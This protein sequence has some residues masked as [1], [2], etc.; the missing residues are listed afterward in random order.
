[1]TMNC[2][3]NLTQF[4]SEKTNFRDKVRPKTFL[5]AMKLNELKKKE[6]SAWRGETQEEVERGNKKSTRLSC[7]CKDLYSGALYL[8][9]IATKIF[10]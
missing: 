10:I 6:K 3:I 7:F 1:M 9:R 4:H 2:P 8:E 5:E